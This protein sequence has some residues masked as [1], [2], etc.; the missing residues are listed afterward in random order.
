MLDTDGVLIDGR[1]E[2]GLPWHTDLARDL[3]IRPEDLQRTFLDR[4]WHD[5]VTGRADLMARLDLALREL[6]A[7]VPAETLRDYWFDNDSR[8]VPEVADWVRRLTARGVPV[9][10]CANLDVRRANHLLDRLGLGS[11]VSGIVYSGALGVAKPDAAF[12]DRAGAAL[13]GA[14]LLLIDDDPAHVEAARRAGWRAV[15][16]RT[17]DDLPGEEG[18]VRNVSRR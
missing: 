4:H 16:Y 18:L 5:I 6:A 12:F 9:H 15:H 10:L 17:P 1:P 8:I 7:P 13:P 11:V 3:G 14:T 2:D